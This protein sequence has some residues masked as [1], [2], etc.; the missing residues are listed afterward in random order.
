MY[1][2]NKNARIFVNRLQPFQGSHTFAEIT[3]PAIPEGFKK[4]ILAAA[5]EDSAAVYAVYS[6]GHHFP[7]YAHI[8]GRWY[9]NK[10]KY[11]CST[12]RHKSQCRPSATITAEVDTDTLT[13]LIKTGVI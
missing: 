4:E 9:A 8:R 13:Q 7:M 12:A 3:R 6:Y 5:G 1:T 11:S 2:A 10:D